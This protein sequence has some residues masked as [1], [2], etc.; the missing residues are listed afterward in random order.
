ML[1]MCILEKNQEHLSSEYEIQLLRVREASFVPMLIPKRK[2]MLVGIQFI[3]VS[4]YAKVMTLN[5]IEIVNMRSQQ[6]LSV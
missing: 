3:I 1:V 6:Y 2:S 5:I 4:S